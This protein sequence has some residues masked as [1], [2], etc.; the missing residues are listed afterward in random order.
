MYKVFQ[1]MVPGNHQY[2]V[3]SLLNGMIEEG[4]LPKNSEVGGEV[5]YENGQCSIYVHVPIASEPTEVKFFSGPNEVYREILEPEPEITRPFPTSRIL[6][7][8]SEGM[9]LETLHRVYH[10]M[11]ENITLGVY[12]RHSKIL[13]SYTK[14][15][16]YLLVVYLEY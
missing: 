7:E 14:D 12:E 16:G 10:T 2:A 3:L 15:V 13:I 9:D 6:F 8:S 1:W 11:V 4:F 5:S